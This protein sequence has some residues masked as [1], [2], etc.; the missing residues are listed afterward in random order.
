LFEM[1]NSGLF[2]ANRDFEGWEE[3]ST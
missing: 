3:G 1:K 2:K